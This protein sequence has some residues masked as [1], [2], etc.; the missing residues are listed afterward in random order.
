MVDRISEKFVPN[1]RKDEVLGDAIEGLQRFQN[2]VVGKW[3]QRE[4]KKKEREQKRLLRAMIGT[5][6]DSNEEESNAGSETDTSTDSAA[7]VESDKTTQP[8]Q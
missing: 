8:I 4:K 7:T 2:S 1:P 5:P 3:E 6:T